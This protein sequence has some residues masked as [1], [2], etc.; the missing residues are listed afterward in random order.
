MQ[1]TCDNCRKP[2]EKWE[3]ITLVKR[4]RSPGRMYPRV[5]S[6]I[7]MTYTKIANLCPGCMEE[8]EELYKI[9]ESE[10]KK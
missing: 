1:N 8:L 7:S 4:K 10:E 9:P 6:D 3:G 2:L 5:S